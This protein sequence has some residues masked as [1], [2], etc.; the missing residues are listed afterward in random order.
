VNRDN[1]A[2]YVFLEESLE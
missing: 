1:F 2:G